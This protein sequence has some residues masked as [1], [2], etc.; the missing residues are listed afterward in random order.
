MSQARIL[1]HS[2]L[3][4]DI[5]DRMGLAEVVDRKVGPRP[6]EK[7]S[8]GTALKAAV[9]N[10]L[11][12]VASPVHHLL[13]WATPLLGRPLS[14]LLTPVVFQEGLAHPQWQMAPR[15]GTATRGGCLSR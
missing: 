1:T 10:A 3:A 14:A 12:F 4:A 7:I 6:G 5:M 11:G 13:L 15:W 2:G 9:L 8:T